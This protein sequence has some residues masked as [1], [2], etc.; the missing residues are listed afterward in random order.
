M[1]RQNTLI[2][3]IRYLLLGAICLISLAIMAFILWIHTVGGSR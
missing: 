3:I 1:N 2:K